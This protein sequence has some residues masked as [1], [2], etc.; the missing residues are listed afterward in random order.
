MIPYQKRVSP[1][2]FKTSQ[3][4]V[5]ELS[6]LAI[7]ARKRNRTDDLAISRA[8]DDYQHTSQSEFFPFPP[9]N[10][11]EYAQQGI[12]WNIAEKLPELKSINH[13]E[14]F[15]SGY[16]QG[17]LTTKSIDSPP[18]VSTLCKA[19]STPNPQQQMSPLQTETAMQFYSTESSKKVSL[20]IPNSVH[21]AITNSLN[22]FSSHDIIFQNQDRKVSGFKNQTELDQSSSQSML[23]SMHVQPPAT[24]HQ[25]EL[26]NRDS[27]YKFKDTIYELESESLRRE[28]LDLGSQSKQSSLKRN[29]MSEFKT[30]VPTIPITKVHNQDLPIDSRESF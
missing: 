28:Q 5:I 16:E 4:L 18:M 22:R 3:L 10:E 2:S 12:I 20:K 11:Q 9:C 1:H 24:N 6:E 27:L 23:K 17:N 26:G 21:G 19:Y 30:L 8:V 25:R 15:T 7:Q 29:L 14:A 13:S